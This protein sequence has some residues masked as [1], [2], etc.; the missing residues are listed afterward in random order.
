MFTAERV[1][2]LVVIILLLLLAL[3]Q[4]C[5][6]GSARVPAVPDS[7]SIQQVDSLSKVPK[8][9]TKKSRKKSSGKKQSTKKPSTPP[10]TRTHR[11]D[12]IQG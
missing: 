11:T 5:G 10:Y 8:K 6:R 7:A 4:M 1:G 3:T 2:L 12:T 9:S